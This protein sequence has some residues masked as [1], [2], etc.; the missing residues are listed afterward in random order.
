MAIQ[1]PLAGRQG[2]G[3]VLDV[4]TGVLFIGI[5]QN[6][7]RQR[8]DIG[9]FGHFFDLVAR[10]GPGLQ[11]HHFDVAGL[12]PFRLDVL[13]MKFELRRLAFDFVG[14]TIKS[15]RGEAR[16]L[17]PAAVDEKFVKDPCSVRRAGDFRLP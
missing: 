16:S 6:A 10:L 17:G 12:R 4:I 3:S 2:A 8:N 11:P 14:D 1:A 15:G 9:G 7:A 13:T 5:L